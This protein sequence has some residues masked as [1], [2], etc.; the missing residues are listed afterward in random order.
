MHVPAIALGADWIPCYFY[1]MDGNS[2]H[3]VIKLSGRAVADSPMYK[4]LAGWFGGFAGS[5]SWGTSSGIEKIVDGGRHWD[6][7]N[8]SGSVYR[9]V[10]NC[11][12]FSMLTTSQFLLFKKQAKAR[13]KGD[14]SIERVLISEIPFMQKGEQS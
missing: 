1:T 7:H 3:Q 2:R 8:F 6:I 5:D 14:V 9:C 12:R 13:R 11:E 4:V 10:K